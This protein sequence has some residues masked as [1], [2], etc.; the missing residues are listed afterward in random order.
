MGR[1]RKK[2]RIAACVRGQCSCRAAGIC[3]MVATRKPSNSY[4]VGVGIFVG[5]LMPAGLNIS[6]VSGVSLHSSLMCTAARCT[7][8]SAR[9][10]SCPTSTSK[11]VL[12][13]ESLGSTAVAG[14]FLFAA[15]RCRSDAAVAG[16]PG[17]GARLGSACVCACCDVV[18]TGA[19]VVLETGQ[20]MASDGTCLGGLG[21]CPMSSASSRVI[22]AR[23]MPE[24]DSCMRR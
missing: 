21:L 7:N 10:S 14:A 18:G 22:Y 11:T 6:I 12:S 8:V 5:T 17:S 4:V 19:S 1:N 9:W 20:A 13:P 2:L 23:S 3:R 24:A 15:V 16:R